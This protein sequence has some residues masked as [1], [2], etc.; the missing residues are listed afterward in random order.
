MLMSQ[1]TELSRLPKRKDLE[2]DG[3]KREILDWEP[4]VVL[5][6][7]LL[8]VEEDQRD[9]LKPGWYGGPIG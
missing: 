4:K 2:R 6:D 8:L 3:S 5:R 1:R 7:G 9:L